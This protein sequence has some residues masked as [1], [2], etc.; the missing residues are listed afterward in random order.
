[1]PIIGKSRAVRN[2]SEFIAK[3]ARCETNLLILGE[4]GTGKELMAR[5]IHSMG[6]RSSRAFVAINCTDIPEDLFEAELFGYARG[7]FTG[8]IKEKP[9]LL[10]VAQGGTVFL[11]EIGSLSAALQTKLLRV[12]ESKEIRRIGETNFRTIEVRFI[13]A[14]NEHLPDGVKKGT[15]RMDLYYRISVLKFVVPPL[16]ERKEDI[17]LLAEYFLDHE[18]QKWNAQKTLSPGAVNKLMSHDFPGN[19]RELENIIERAFVLSD[20]SQIQDTDLQIEEGFSPQKDVLLGIPEQLRQIL[21]DCR[22]NKTRAASE[23]GKSRRQFYRILEKYQMSDC[24]R[25]N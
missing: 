21:G 25:K 13:F 5:S 1:M 4:T 3:A 16:R 24:I 22:W 17:P 11:D 6:P 7:S 8:A 15:F 10:E 18:N 2:K 20:S 14:T 9:G 12:V 19:I 23:I